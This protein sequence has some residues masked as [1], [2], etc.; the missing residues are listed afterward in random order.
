MQEVLE[1]WECDPLGSV[2]L[3]PAGERERFLA[4]FLGDRFFAHSW[5][6]PAWELLGPACYIA[7]YGVR[8]WEWRDVA[9]YQCQQRLRDGCSAAPAHQAGSRS[10]GRSS[11]R[12]QQRSEGGGW[13][14]RENQQRRKRWR[15]IRF[16]KNSSLS[17]TC[18]AVD[19]LQVHAYTNCLHQSSLTH[20]QCNDKCPRP[21][22]I[23]KSQVGFLN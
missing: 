19:V 8:C 7:I 4:P 16:T 15:Q 1:C 23:E 12:C 18:S 11:P 2:V 5:L 10:D 17:W 21:L 3:P 22:F 13:E 6:Q 9:L 20:R 14:V